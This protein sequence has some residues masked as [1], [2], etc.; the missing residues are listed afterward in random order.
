MKKRPGKD[1]PST[2]T[3]FPLPAVALIISSSFKGHN[4]GPGQGA[5]LNIE[6]ITEKTAAYWCR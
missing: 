4:Y 6:L 3:T 1:V 2:F 5:F